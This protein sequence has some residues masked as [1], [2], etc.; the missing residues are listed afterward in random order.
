MSKADE[1]FECEIIGCGRQAPD[2]QLRVNPMNI[3]ENLWMCDACNAEKQENADRI[4][5]RFDL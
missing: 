1:D 4:K 5:E 2:V 3:K